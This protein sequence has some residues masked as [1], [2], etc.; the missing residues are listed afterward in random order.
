MAQVSFAALIPAETK[1]I[2][3]SFLATDMDEN[4][5]VEQPEASAYEF[6]GQALVDMLNKL[7]EKF[8]DEQVDLEKQEE[9]AR[10]AYELL[11]RS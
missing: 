4:L 1:R 8:S 3:D 2:I 11:R 9:A 6:H 7:I 5:A 10:Q